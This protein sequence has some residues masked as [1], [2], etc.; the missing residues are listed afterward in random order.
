MFEEIYNEYLQHKNEQNRIERYEGR[1]GWYHASGAG[2]C[3]R[4]L[5]FESVEKA[6][7][8]NIPNTRNMRI[9]G[10]GTVIHNDIQDSLLYYNNIYNNKDNINKV[11]IAQ[12]NM[13]NFHTEGEIE[14]SEFNVRGFYD[15]VMVNNK[16]GNVSLYD[17]K[18]IASYGFRQRFSTKYGVGEPSR[19]HYMQ[20]AT[21]GLGVEK[22][23]GRLNSMDLIYYNKDDSR[24]KKQNV[25]LD[26]LGKAKRFWYTINEEH[27]QG[28]PRFNLGTSPHK[29]WMCSYCQFK[30]HCKPPNFK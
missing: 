30:D 26:Y 24:M 23:F 18:T 22:E 5:Y 9:R 28:L 11:N 14:L 1:E 21:Y 13:H 27:K 12:L 8:T 19:N 29:A 25:P 20:L 4:K 7:P 16:T 2:Y 10:L 17:I 6:E 3:S 15:I